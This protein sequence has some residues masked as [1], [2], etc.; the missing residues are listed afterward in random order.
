MGLIQTTDRTL[1]LLNGEV[2]VIVTTETDQEVRIISIRK[3][4]ILV[5]QGF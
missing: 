5:L 1:G 3:A 2:V 4:T